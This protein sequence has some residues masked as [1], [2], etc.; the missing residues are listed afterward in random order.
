MADTD[1]GT[2]ASFFEPERQEGFTRT[3]SDEKGT[4]RSELWRSAVT[5]FEQL[6]ISSECEWVRLGPDT[7]QANNIGSFEGTG[8]VSGE[9]TDICIDP[10][11]A[12]GNTLYVATNNGG[13]W[14]TTDGGQNWSSTMDLKQSL[15]MGAVAIDPGDSNI[16]YAATGNLFDGGHVFNSGVGIYKSIDAGRSWSV[17]DGGLFATV[18]RGVGINC[19]VLPEPDV[20]LVATTAGLFRSGDGGVNFGSNDPSFDDGKPIRPNMN[21][22]ITSLLVSGTPSVTGPDIFA[23]VFGKGVFRSQDGGRTFPHK[24]FDP[25]GDYGLIALA[26][27][28]Q[29]DSSWL[30]AAVGASRAD[31]PFRGIFL[32]TDGGL[33]WS[34]LPGALTAYQNYKG[35]S[36]VGQ[37]TFDLT[38]GIDP[39]NRQ[40]IYFALEDLFISVPAATLAAMTFNPLTNGNNAHNP[41]HADH[42]A[43]VFSPPAHWGLLPPG[44]TRMYV[45][46]DGGIYQ[47]DDAGANWTAFNNGLATSLFTAI[48]IGRGNPFRVFTGGGTQDTGSSFML[49][50]AVPAHPGVAPPAWRMVRGGDGGQVAIGRTLP[51]TVYG[52]ATGRLVSGA[53]G[54]VG[55]LGNLVQTPQSELPAYD[56]NNAGTWVNILMVDPGNNQILYATVGPG[57]FKTTNGGTTFAKLQSFSDDITALSTTA[58]NSSLLWAGLANGK[59]HRSS[60]ARSNWDEVSPGVEGR[61]VESIAVDP[62]NTSRIAV[63]YSGYS[64]TNTVYRTRHVFLT[65]DNGANWLDISGKDSASPASNLPDIPC[66]SVVIDNDG[67]VIVGTDAGM[68]RSVAID[69]TGATWRSLGAC[70]NRLPGTFEGGFPRTACSSLAL[71]TTLAPAPSLLRVGT[72]GR[73]CF[74]RTQPA[75]Q[76]VAV[77][78]DL[79]FG[80]VEI[81]QVVNREVRVLNLG[82]ATLTISGFAPTAASNPDFQL[83]P[84]PAF[85]ET[86]SAHSAAAPNFTVQFTPSLG[87]RTAEFILQTDDPLDGNHSVFASGFGLG[88]IFSRLAVRANLGFGILVAGESRTVP[89][90]LFNV[91]TASTKITA[92]DRTDGS[93]NFK[94]DPPF[95]PADLA[96]GGSLALSMRFD[97]GFTLGFHSL[98]D[99]QA[100]FAV[101]SNDS[102]SPFLLTAT[103][104]SP[105][106]V[107]LTWI[108]V[109]AIGA[110]VVG[111]GIVGIQALE[112]ATKK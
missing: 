80:S 43:L 51:P 104:S 21:G 32:S 52:S 91:G 4:P 92:I 83:V 71:D 48:D 64:A 27:S 103:A 17:V 7:V 30:V 110:A 39:Q 70:A 62:G 59:V 108:I 95:T 40:R 72:Y 54:I 96:V 101:R 79:A 49:S 36:L 87:N 88:A 13:V 82:G 41:V 28:S 50:P 44:T 31:G 23:A 76:R 22:E 106:N 47:T 38:V 33:S 1:E 45:G 58:Q 63:A 10:K 55:V 46:T 112:N 105:A 98:R 73:G 19:I 93:D 74:E 85:P 2:G 16:V 66:L 78:A 67:T 11:D 53:L 5:D 81:G 18:F 20:L 24:V 84:A 8:N 61:V 69:A 102:R 57:L 65:T 3:H 25:G 94:I 15:S 68:A 111:G 107:V 34:P 42:H 6:L 26:Q 56:V 75:T 35:G 100:T 99:R 60:D 37:T 90:Q 86:V 29:P 77:I 9:V 109:V 12:T 89:F 14:K 97:T